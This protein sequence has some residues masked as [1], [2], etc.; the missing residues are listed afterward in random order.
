[1]ASRL[2]SL[3]LNRPLSPSSAEPRTQPTIDQVLEA[4]RGHDGTPAVVA[5]DTPTPAASVARQ[6][7]A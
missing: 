3:A 7:V 1:M 2:A 4:P 6:L 5:V